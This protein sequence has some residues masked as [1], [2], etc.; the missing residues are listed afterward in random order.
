MR[1]AGVV[2]ARAKHLE[3]LP[4]KRLLDFCMARNRLITPVRGF[5]QRACDPPSRFK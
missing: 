4:S 2:S 3:N 1:E 5:V